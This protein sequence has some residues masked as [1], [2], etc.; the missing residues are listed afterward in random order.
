MVTTA[1]AHTPVLRTIDGVLG[2]RAIVFGS[3]PPE[4]RDIDLLVVPPDEAAVAAR[5]RNDG[6]RSCG[7]EFVSFRGCVPCAVELIP[8]GTLGVPAAELEALFA[9]GVPL[10]GLVNVVEPAP[11]HAL[12]ILARKVGRR[13][14]LP[15]KHRA[16]I[17]RALAQ[18]SDA[19]ERARTRAEAWRA[20]RALAR[21]EAL[22]RDGPRR[23][24]RLHP[25]RPRRT[26]VVAVP[27][28]SAERLRE[29]LARLGFDVVV[30][31]ARGGTI[32]TGAV[33][34]RHAGRGR[35]VLLASSTHTRDARPDAEDC[36]QLAGDAWESL[37]RGRRARI[38]AVAAR[39]DGRAGPPVADRRM[40][41]V[42]LV[43]AD[44][45]GKTTV[46]RSLEHVLPLPAKY[47]YMGVNW[48]AS[49]HLLPTTRLVQAVRR[50]RGT[51]SG[52]GPPDYSESAESRRGAL[53]RARR[54]A[55]SALAL[56]NRLSEEWYR[57][58]LASSY[59]RRGVVVVFDRH[60]FSD[61]YAHDVAGGRPRGIDRRVHGFLLEHVYPKPDLVVFLDAPPEVLFARKGEGTLESLERRRQEYLGLA[62]RTPHFVTV[63][64]ARPLDDVMQDVVAVI[65]AFSERRTTPQA[66]AGVSP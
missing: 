28:P 24:R 4:G 15:P 5:L 27:A 63:D 13:G 19:W 54:A 66:V 38:G 43:G 52:G 49:D 21:L 11:H 30:E 17:E 57:Q 65:A 48:D 32:A 55:W 53:A 50:A 25:R 26:R 47:L 12:L 33:L 39:T 36:E 51:A 2:G 14:E 45:A 56:A 34:L 10:D 59:V 22:H 62:A 20:A 1:A 8:A 46:A 60:F 42:A 18:D 41:S 61:Y 37:K 58:A 23:A 6:F 29:P 40:F 7:R 31:R 3:L 16:R 35:V 44:G 9:D 64:A